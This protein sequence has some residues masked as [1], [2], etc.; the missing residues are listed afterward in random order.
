M[1]R[2][3]KTINEMGLGVGAVAGGM[4]KLGDPAK[5]MSQGAFGE[6]DL[7]MGPPGMEDELD[8]LGGEGL[9]DEEGESVECS[10]AE[11]QELLSAVEMGETSAEEAFDQLCVGD[12]DEEGL[13]ELG[14][15]LGDEGGLGDELGGLGGPVGGVGPGPEVME[16]VSR[17]SKIARLLTEDPDIFRS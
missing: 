12:C 14:D 6:D 8:D 2:K 15:E 9:E 13:G 17:I 1:T 7:D 10:K 16:S 5:K 4:D 11:L 3:R